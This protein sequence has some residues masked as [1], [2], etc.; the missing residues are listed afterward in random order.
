M[1][2]LTNSEEETQDL[3]KKLLEEYPEHRVW[4]LEGDLA[5]GKTQLVKGLAKALGI[6]K[7]VSSP[8]YAYLNEY[9]SKLAHYDLYRL[10][11]QDEELMHL[12]DEHL[13]STGH[14]VIEWPSRMNVQVAQ[15]HLFIRINHEGGSKRSL[16]ITARP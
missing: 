9:S 14:V 12:I 1:Q 8:T 2:V 15:A 10:E 4:L 3:A 5:A 6:E 16:E 11:G 13:A 7:A